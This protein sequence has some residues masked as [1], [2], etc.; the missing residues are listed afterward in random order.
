[1]ESVYASLRT[2]RTTLSSDK[3]TRMRAP[4]R[5]VK[6][7]MDDYGTDF[8]R[9]GQSR[10]KPSG[11][12]QPRTKKS[13][14]DDSF[15]DDFMVLSE[16]EDELDLLPKR[17]RQSSKELLQ[18]GLRKKE[19]QGKE[20]AVSFLVDGRRYEPHPDYATD[21]KK[22]LAG[23]KF[24]KKKDT[25][26]GPSTSSA[27]SRSTPESSVATS[28]KPVA[29][30]TTQARG[31]SREDRLRKPFVPP[32]RID[33]GNA[34]VRK[35]SPPPRKR[36]T[37]S[38]PRFS[39]DEDVEQTPRPP[40]K[41]APKPRPVKKGLI[42]AL[43]E[44]ASSQGTVL[45]SAQDNRKGKGK[46][47]EIEEI[48]DWPMDDISPPKTSSSRRASDSEGS[49]RR[50]FPLKESK[51]AKSNARPF[52]MDQLS[53]IK[54]ENG[55]EDAKD[56]KKKS[57]ISPS[58]SQTSKRSTAPQK[59][60]PPARPIQE[61][62]ALSPLSSPAKPPPT[63][64]GSTHS[65]QGAQGKK[66]KDVSQGT[67]RSSRVIYSSEDPSESEGELKPVPPRIKARPF[68]MG[69]Q[70][71]EGLGNSSFK[72]GSS[73]TEFSDWEDERKKTKRVRGADEMC[74]NAFLLYCGG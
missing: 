69:T 32:S 39:S 41:T 2:R 21:G 50:S 25:E 28:N 42:S 47:R 4:P 58:N 31:L 67:A 63:S 40:T 45:A 10:S 48:E 29:R 22:K 34:A 66:K 43:D 56:K 71:L 60:P 24:K 53:P 55:S 33:K 15:A 62:P 7:T 59:P 72:R 38:I 6:N 51:S 61:F 1:M 37:A 9:V 13:G 52:P 73:D 12:T 74:V 57:R 44:I 16:S 27:T 17:P 46:A 35:P 14:A 5:P 30:P 8:G 26:A 65:S 68:P 70:M 49:V 36:F 11:K 19:V 64:Q 23:L 54:G 18:N 20:G 3:E